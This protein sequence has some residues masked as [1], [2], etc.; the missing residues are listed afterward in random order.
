[1]SHHAAG[2]SQPGCTQRYPGGHGAADRRRIVRVPGPHPTAQ[3]DYP[4]IG[5]RG[6]TGSPDRLGGDR[7]P[8]SR[9]RQRAAGRGSCT[10]IVRCGRS[11]PW[12]GT[13]PA[14]GSDGQISMNA[15]PSA[16]PG[17]RDSVHQPPRCAGA[18]RASIAARTNRR[19]LRINRPRMRSVPS[20]SRTKRRSGGWFVIRDAPIGS[21]IACARRRRPA[22]W[23][24][25]KK[26]V[27][28]HRQCLLDGRGGAVGS[29][30]RE[31]V[32]PADHLTCSGL[33]TPRPYRSRRRQRPRHDLPLGDTV[34]VNSRAPAPAPLL[35][36][37]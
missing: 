13:S 26:R 29:T 27:G 36:R 15:P 33:N 16:G 2:V 11:P 6:I 14:V 22:N 1:M 28:V 20:R 21:S 19:P 3:S 37:G 30:R 7:L 4:H 23:A 34:A 12:V 24:G 35:R 32:P 10:V 17:L 8:V 31:A 9:S 5:D 25:S 18:A